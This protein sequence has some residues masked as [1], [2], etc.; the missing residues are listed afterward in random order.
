MRWITESL[1]RLSR[2]QAGIA[3]IFEGL[4]YAGLRLV[5][6]A[7]GEVDKWQI[8]V[9]GATN[10]V[11]LKDL[12]QRSRRL[13]DLKKEPRQAPACHGSFLGVCSPGYFRSLKNAESDEPSRKVTVAR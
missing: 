12:S 4:R 7:E 13:T 6:V 3:T 9:L 2:S 11:Y 8:G 1:D 10:A 5:T